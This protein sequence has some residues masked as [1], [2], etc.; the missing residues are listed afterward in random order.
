MNKENIIMITNAYKLKEVIDTTVPHLKSI[1][2]LRAS[3]KPYPEKWSIKEILGHLI[4]S[5][6]N[7]HQRIVR[8]QEILDIGTFRYTQ[9][10][11]VSS[12]NYQK[13]TWLDIVE[14]WHRYNAHLSHIIEQIAP[15][16]LV[17]VC[18]VG[19]PQPVTL[20]FIIEDY[21][22]HLEHHL[23]QILSDNDPRERKAHVKSDS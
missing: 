23:G 3:E 15:G 12:Q 18:D 11:W 16:L 13:E 6:A 21:I 9:L 1:S 22:N 5:A 14:F 8:M 10:H 2:E 17:H 7:N 19:L 4:D 20:E